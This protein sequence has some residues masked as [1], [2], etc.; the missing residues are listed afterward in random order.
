VRNSDSGSTEEV[1]AAFFYGR[2]DVIPEMFDRLLTTLYG[3]KHD[4]DRLRHFIYYIDRHTHADRAQFHLLQRDDRAFM[5]L[6]VRPH[7]DAASG[8]AVG[9]AAQV[10][11]ERVE[12][13]HQRGSLDGFRQTSGEPTLLTVLAVPLPAAPEMVV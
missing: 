3:A 4:D 7:V 11:L 5:G 2:E 13:D 1:L 12:I 6:G 10:A 8:D 9:Q